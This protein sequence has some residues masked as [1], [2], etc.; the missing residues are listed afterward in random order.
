MKAFP[1]AGGGM[2]KIRGVAGKVP[3]PPLQKL[4][5]K[6]IDPL[7]TDINYTGN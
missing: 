1:E 3:P 2:Q 4:L 6:I 7:D 5:T